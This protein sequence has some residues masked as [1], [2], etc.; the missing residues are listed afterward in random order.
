M[1]IF[2]L[3]LFVMLALCGCNKLPPATAVVYVQVRNINTFGPVG[4]IAV[5]ISKTDNSV[6]ATKL[7]HAKGAVEFTQL[8]AGTYIIKTNQTLSI[9]DAD[10]VMLADGG[11]ASVELSVKE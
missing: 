10:T 9:P 5:S 8:Q 3:F 11:V 4:N 1:K 7:S 2:T 6:L